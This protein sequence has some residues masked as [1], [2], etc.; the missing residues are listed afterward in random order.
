MRDQRYGNPERRA[1]RGEPVVKE[2]GTMSAY[3]RANQ[4]ARVGRAV[5]MQDS[6]SGEYPLSGGKLDLVQETLIVECRWLHE[7]HESPWVRVRKRV[8]SRSF[9]H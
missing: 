7:M 8:R 3:A 2:L 4:D 5:P 9:Q 1:K 6:L